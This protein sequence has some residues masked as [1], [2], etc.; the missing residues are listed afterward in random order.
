MAI[1]FNSFQPL[2]GAKKWKAIHL[3]YPDL[4]PFIDGSCRREPDFENDYPSISALCRGGKFVHR[5]KQNDIVAYW[6]VQNAYLDVRKNHY[7]L[8]A[9]LRVMECFES[10]EIA[11]EWYSAK[12]QKLPSNCMIPEKNAPI[13]WGKT[14]QKPVLKW[15]ENVD[16]WDA[17]YEKRKGKY[18]N[19][20]ACQP[21]YRELYNPQVISVAA[22]KAEFGKIPGT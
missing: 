5:L 7:R 8:V 21:L 12:M 20:V 22:M 4:P 16:Q 6:T 9:I 15:I 3:Q 14:N 17:E 13:V 1:Y 11:A 19:F 2:C 10:H 18:G